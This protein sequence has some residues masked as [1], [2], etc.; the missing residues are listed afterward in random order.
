MITGIYNLIADSSWALSQFQ[1]VRL[2]CDTTLGAVTINLPAISTLAISTNLKLIVVDVTANASVNNITINAG[3]T[4]LPPVSDTF[5]DSTTNQIILDTNG[6]SVIFQNVAATQ[7]IATESVS[8]GGGTLPTTQ[9]N[10]QNITNGLTISSP[11]NRIFCIG[12]TL[13]NPPISRFGGGSE[14]ILCSVSIPAN[15]FRLGDYTENNELLQLDYTINSPNETIFNFYY[16]NQNDLSGATLFYTYTDSGSIGVNNSGI[17]I[18]FTESFTP[19]PRP[20]RV[21]GL[22]FTN[23][24]TLTNIDFTVLPI[25]YNDFTIF[26]ITT[27]T[28]IICT[29]QLTNPTDLV[30]IGRISS[31]L[32]ILQAIK[33]VV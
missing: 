27:E 5:D 4:G 2:E 30:N 26:D 1:E 17:T 3:A 15:S 10:I 23:N 31:Y 28:W 32:P 12:D 24:N 11:I 7:W 16:N 22:Q 14:E 25:Q 13:I 8:G 19:G 9:G 18:P 21:R 33:S 20:Q 29:I 6:S